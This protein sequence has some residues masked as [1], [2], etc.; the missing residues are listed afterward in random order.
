M[1]LVTQANAPRGEPAGGHRAESREPYGGAAAHC[2]TPADGLSYD[3]AK[4]RKI[5]E[6]VMR[7]EAVSKNRPADLINLVL[8]EGRRGRS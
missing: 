5:A 8:G 6:A 1:A 2:R 3:K 4:A 7:S